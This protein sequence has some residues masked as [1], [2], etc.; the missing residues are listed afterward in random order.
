M[1]PAE[2]L[3]Q[4][5][6]K[7]SVGASC[8]KSV[9]TTTL[10]EAERPTLEPQTRDKHRSNIAPMRACMHMSATR[11]QPKCM[12][13][14]THAYI[15]TSAPNTG[16]RAC[17][18]A[19]TRSQAQ[20]HSYVHAGMRLRHARSRVLAHTYMECRATYACPVRACVWATYACPVR[21]C[22]WATY[23]CPM[24]MCAR[25]RGWIS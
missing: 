17:V 14:H 25:A 19:Y 5:V 10:I 18:H 8:R 9:A 22:A 21:A 15:H 1:S 23:A 6:A 3:A 11:T 7:Q 12:R 13:I 20:A 4:V 24:C 16:P 2:A